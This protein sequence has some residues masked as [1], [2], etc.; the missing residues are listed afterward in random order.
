[1]PT[2]PRTR[3]MMIDGRYLISELRTPRIGG[4]VACRMCGA[5]NS[6]ER[7]NLCCV[8]NFYRGAHSR[9]VASGRFSE[10]CS[11]MQRKLTM[12][13]ACICFVA[14]LLSAQGSIA[15]DL[16]PGK[17]PAGEREK[18]EQQENASWSPAT[19]GSVTGSA[20]MVSA[21]VSPVAVYAGLQALRQG[22]TAAD[23]AATTALT[24]ITTQLG[25][26]VSYAGVFTMVYF[27]AKTHR[28]YSL[29]AG[30]NS[31]LNEN[32][33]ASIPVAD[34]GI[35]LPGLTPSVG[36]AKGRETLVPGFMA[37]LEAMHKR[38]GKL[39]FKQLFAPALWYD[40][41]GVLLSPRLAGYFTM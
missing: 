18:L 13:H 5:L 22:G 31:Y 17:W 10:R 7:A 28:I 41:H 26:V 8:L 19:A 35:A 38:F 25:S 16:S 30:Y 23:A 4:G 14:A 29:D 11:S 24:Q 27:D 20:G 6:A 33:P 34:F 37:G 21:T 12:K 3:E 39:P 36:G 15:A 32:D 9:L 1:M 2:P 40:T